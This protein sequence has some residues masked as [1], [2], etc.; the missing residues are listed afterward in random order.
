MNHASNTTETSPI[1]N[2]T[3]RPADDKALKILPR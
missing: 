1:S 2:L 3:L